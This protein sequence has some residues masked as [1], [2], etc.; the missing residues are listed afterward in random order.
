MQISKQSLNKSLEKEIWEI[1]YQLLVDIKD[2]EE[3]K[4]ISSDVLGKDESWTIAKRLTIAY[5]L[6]HKRSYTNIK[7]NLKVS[8]A[9]IAAVEKESKKKGYQLALKRIMADKW[10]TEWSSK[11]KSLFNK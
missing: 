10:A 4:I 6:H 8:S 1:Y 2:L 11:I 3:A 9:I 5:Y 7:N